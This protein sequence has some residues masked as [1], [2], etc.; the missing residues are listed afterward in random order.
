[1]YIHKAAINMHLFIYYLL[2]IYK[3]ALSWKL[4]RIIAHVRTSFCLAIITVDV[5][6]ETRFSYHMVDAMTFIAI[7]FHFSAAI[8]KCKTC[9]Y[10]SLSSC[11]WKENDRFLIVYK[12]MR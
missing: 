8:R 10:V 3:G 5:F 1:M 6:A 7:T 12:P 11:D 2:F 9:F 4:S